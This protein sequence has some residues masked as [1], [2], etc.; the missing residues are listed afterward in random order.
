MS[1][2]S[3]SLQDDDVKVRLKRGDWEIEIT[4]DKDKVKGVVQDVLSGIDI[5]TE[6]NVEIARKFEEIR[7][8]IAYLKLRV[9]DIPEI[10]YARTSDSA[11]STGATCRGLIG[12]LSKEGYF[13]SEKT[14]GQVHEELSRRGYNYD[15][16]AVSHALT[17]M[18]REGNLRRVGT[19]RN[20]RYLQREH[21]PTQQTI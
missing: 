16:T 17:D 8:E 4:C 6:S 1:N 18:V 19:M 11:M 21:I 15:R 13:E 7:A 12:L 3:P 9:I 5:S 10:Q 20:Y 14:L 2:H